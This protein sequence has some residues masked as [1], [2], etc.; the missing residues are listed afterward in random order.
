MQNPYGKIV[1]M[2]ADNSVAT[3]VVEAQ[4]ACARCAEGRGCGAGLLGGQDRE[5]TIQ[6]S[7]GANVR[8]R[9]GDA[10]SIALQPRNILRASFVVYGYPMLGAV[11]GAALAWQANL[12]DLAAALAA[13]SGIAVGL[14]VARVRLK[15]TS[16]L[17]DF[18]PV[19]VGRM[20]ENV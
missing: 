7:V 9:N 17:R 12:G 1:A 8:V 18:T 2:S 10:V 14:A 16:C 20:A 5:S 3:V 11:A 15:A 4:S 13:L 19:V 6:A